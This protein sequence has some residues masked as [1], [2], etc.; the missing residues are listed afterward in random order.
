ME[1]SIR[2]VLQ[3]RVL[4]LGVAFAPFIHCALAA[5]QSA[6][7]ML[8]EQSSKISANFYS[9]TGAY[10]VYF[11]VKP[12]EEV[13]KMFQNLDKSVDIHSSV[14]AVYRSPKTG[15]YIKYTIS[16]DPLGTYNSP[17]EY[18]NNQIESTVDFYNKNYAQFDVKKLTHHTENGRY[19]DDILIKFMSAATATE[20]AHI[21]LI[22]RFVFYKNRHVFILEALGSSEYVLSGKTDAFFSTFESGIED[23]GKPHID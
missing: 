1:I 3:F 7:R 19:G 11:P 13:A 9:R 18:I 4:F 12:G 16:I 10:K 15:N 8:N 2:A 14:S 6:T 23:T 20:P 22:R 17:E 21:W 5:D